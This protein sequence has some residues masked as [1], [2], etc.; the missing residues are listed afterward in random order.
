MTVPEMK[1]ALA[2]L[3]REM[4]SPPRGIAHPVQTRDCTCPACVR[5]AGQ[6]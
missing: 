2:T 1:D 6:R 5:K 4:K 3:D